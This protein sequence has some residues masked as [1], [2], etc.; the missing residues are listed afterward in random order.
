MS[1]LIAAAV[2]AANPL[3][4]PLASSYS[5]PVPLVYKLSPTQLTP[6]QNFFY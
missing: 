6:K 4:Y 3:C 2:D 5:R 1:H